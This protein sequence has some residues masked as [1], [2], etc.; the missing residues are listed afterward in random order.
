MP[1]EAFIDPIPEAREIP[2]QDGRTSLSK[3]P[4]AGAEKPEPAGKRGT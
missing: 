3:E 2:E 4:E 1:K